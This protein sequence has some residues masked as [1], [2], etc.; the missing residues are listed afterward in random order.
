ML[1][2]TPIST[3]SSHSSLSLLLVIYVTPH[4]HLN[5]LVSFVSIL[6]SSHLCYST[7]PSQQ[8]RLIRLYPCFFS[9]MLLHTSISNVLVSFVSILA[10]CHLC[11][12]AHPSQHPRLIRLYPCVLSFMLLHTPVSTS[13]SHS[14][15]SLLLV[16]YV[17]PHIRL[18]ILVS[19][20]SILASCHLCYSTHPSQHPRLIHLYPCFLSFMLLHTSVS[21]SSSHS[22][23]SLLLL[24]YVTSHIH[25]NI[26]VSFVSILASFIYVTPHIRLNILVSFVSILA[27]SHLCY[28]THPSQHPRLIRLYPCFL[29]FMLLHTSISTS[30]SHSSLSLLL[31]IYVTPHIHLNIL[32][33]FVSILAS[34]HLCYSTH[35]PQHP[36]LIR[37]YPCFLSFML[38]HTSTSTSSS[39]SSLS[40]LL[41]IYVTPH[42]HLNILVSFVSIL[43]SCHLCYSTH[44]P[45][46]PRLIRLY[47]CF[48]SFM[49]LHTSFSTSSS[50]SSLS[51]LLVI[52]VTPH[53]PLNILVSF[54]S[55]LASCHLRYSTHPSQ[56]PRLIRLYPCVLSFMLLHTSTSTSSSHSSLSL[57]LVIY[58]T[59][60][61]H[62]NIL[63]SFV[64]ILASCH[65]C[66]STHPS[67][68][69]RLIR[70][71]P[72]FLSFMLLHTS[73][74]TSSSHSSL[75][76]L[77]VIYVTPHI[78]LNI[79]VSFV[80]ILASCHLRYST[81]PS[82][83]PRLIR[84][85]PCV[86]SFTLLHTSISNVLV[87]FVSIL[88]SCHLRY[89]THPSQH[90]RL[91]RLYPCFLSFTLL[92]TSISTS[93]S[94]SSL[95]LL[96]VIYVTPHIHLNIV[97]SFVSSL[98][99][100]HLRYST[101][102]S[103]HPHLIRLYPCF[104]SFMLLHA[105][106]S[107]SS[108]HSSL[109][110]LLVIYVTPYIHL[111]ILVS[112]VS[113]LASCH[114]CYFTHP[115]QHPRLIRLYPCF[116]SFMLLHASISTS[117][118]H[119]SLSLLLVIYVTPYIHLNILVS[120]VSI[121]ASCHL[122]YSTHPSQ[123]PHLIRLY[124]CFLSFMLLHAS[125]S[126]SSSHS[127]L[128]LLLV[129]YVTPCIHLNILISFVSILA[130]CHLC[131]STHPSQHPHLIRLYPC[132]LSFM[133]LHASI[134]TSSSHSSLALLLIIYVTPCIHL[135]ILISFVSI[136]ASCHLCY[137]THPSQH[138]R[139]IRLYPCFLSFTLL[140][141]SISTSSS[142]SSLSLLLVI[143]VTPC[144][145]LNIL[146]SFVS[147]LASCHLCYS[148][149]PSQHPRLIR[150][151]PC[152]LSFMLLHT[153]I[154]TSSSHSSLSLLLV[155]YVTPCIHLN[156]LIS[157]VSILASCHLCYS[158]HPSQHPR[159]IRLYP[160]FLSFML[161][162]A[163]IS[164]SSSHSSLSLLLVIYVTPYI[165]LNIL[166]SFVSI[167]ASCHLRYSTHPS[168]HP[169]LIRLYPCFL[170]FML[171][172]ASI[173]TYSSHS[174]LSLLLVIYVTPCI[175]LNIL[176]SFVSI[177]ASC[178]LCYSTHPS[179]HRRLI[180]LYPCFLSFTLLHTSISTS[181]SH[182]SLSL[183]LVIYVTPCI[184]LNILIS[185][186]SIL[187]SCHLCYSI[188]PSQHP[189][190][191]RLYPCFLS[192]MLLHTSISTSSSHSSLSLLLVIYVTPCIHLNILI[193]F[194][195]IL[196]SCNLCYSTHPSQHPHLI[197]L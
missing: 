71:C 120:F 74:S 65:L 185:F 22:S 187:A 3:S 174:S 150:L 167:L 122:R 95:S 57:L 154:S 17:T 151:Y 136:L 97:V 7:H 16:I 94:H 83:H 31:V 32:V 114:L 5:I 2:H 141:T 194:I 172:H 144:I 148:I 189:R 82:Q 149:H 54:V 62:L 66:Y 123:H 186:V 53:I 153:S 176:I 11:Y 171:L 178:H 131:Y 99:S 93:S 152:F 173:S 12:S 43:A 163:S 166:V 129:I 116:L 195:S 177:L 190:L 118:S 169:H 84:L 47:P 126:T 63:V 40:L 196:A 168:Q 193:S 46:H 130:S 101:H 137:S 59:P 108:S 58:V 77:L 25:L 6:A 182:S 92:H 61:I 56:H 127:S 15:L 39:H 70:L 23:L 41:V 90:P 192:F 119:S 4:I 36:R 188:H 165:H 81:H 161:L 134:S 72:C 48:L 183:L 160:C 1:L 113:I 49:L 21:T 109:S 100:C 117:S 33:S 68:H 52:Y 51:L 89:S 143:Y 75:S 64:S 44:P 8:P 132:F 164:T 112:F 159:L 9:F 35:P 91:I 19:F 79:L 139:L 28:F 78:H 133:L 29:S 156:I 110:L 121:L 73:I 80:S 197:R 60:H 67:Q 18:N 102:P 42:I 111:N 138:R 104:L 10:S 27:S 38:L 155:I 37:L 105:S 125:I 86:L 55:I 34:C 128:S 140:H 158:I 50:H 175:H 45:Q 30:S 157:F 26:L 142:H 107:T 124:P 69:P 147:I 24:I 146:I 98:A 170:S 184:H 96:L 179:Q 106:I 162:H 87:S 13:S 88:A 76:L 20:V 14:S 135:N 181:S 180:R 115:S 145:H 191:I 85:Y 103:Q